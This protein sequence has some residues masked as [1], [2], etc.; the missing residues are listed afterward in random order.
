MQLRGLAGKVAFITGGGTGVG[1]ASARRLAAEGAR[2]AVVGRTEHTLKAVVQDIERAGGAALWKRC[3]VARRDQ[4]DAAV[5]ATVERFGR[6]D[7]VVSNA[8]IQLHGI[9]KPL[10]E[11][12]D[13]AWDKT[14]DVN[15][16]GAFFTLR[17]GVR[18]ILKHGQGGALVVVS[19]VTALG[20]LAPQNPAY[21][22]T[23]GGL[24]ALGRALAVQYAKDNIR[25]NVVCPG[26]L[27][28]PP[29][30]ELMGAEGPQARMAR[31]LPQIP[32]GRLGRFE[33]MGPLVAFL[34][35]D[36]ASYCTGGVFVADGGL[37]A[38]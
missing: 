26:A 14:H 33:E 9:D 36:D 6:L 21:T 12:D 16:R 30:V 29:D 8:A 25:C 1:A 38:R 2:V 5:A 28:A 34:C 35:S 32:L 37:T 15:L 17:A 7:A 31:L 10:H 11:A 18:E 3:D 22:S 27:E 20:G 19:S 4:V 13:D 24:L 23:K